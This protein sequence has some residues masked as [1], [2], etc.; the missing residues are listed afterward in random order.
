VTHR[1][2]D[3]LVAGASQQ[4]T[5]TYDVPCST[6][7]QAQL[8]NSATVSGTNL[9][10]NPEVNTSNNTA[11]V[12]TTV[13]APVVTLAKS[14]SSSVNAGG[15]ITYRITYENTGSGDAKSVVITDTLPADVYYSTALDLGA[16]PAP[17]SVAHNANGTTTLTWTI[18]SVP[19][20]SGPST[21]EYTAR[22]SL[23]FLGG[24]S[25]ANGA[26][27]TF[28]N[29]N[30]CTYSPVTASGTTGITVVPPTRNPLSMGYWKT[31]PGEWTSEILAR[32]QATDQRYD[33]AD[34]SSP[35]GKLSSAEVAAAF[36][37]NGTQPGTLQAQLLGTYFNLAT[38]RINAGTTIDSKTDRRLALHNVREA[39]LY[40]M[41]TLAL[42]L[43]GNTNRYGDAITVLDEINLNKSEI[44]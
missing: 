43:S 7:D 31:H 4:K 21:I 42:P 3:M 36:G 29:A 39:A 23:L 22:P 5:V 1:S 38:R 9:L 18:G 8:E 27:V 13:H 2:F 44:Y 28:T 20:G 24:S 33:G 25:V 37:A 12:T 26:E 17:G 10:N 40:G 34:G 35:D 11:S 19:G 30:G 32:I 16:G 6:A 15:A 41:A 14:A